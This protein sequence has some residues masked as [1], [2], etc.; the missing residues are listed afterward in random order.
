[1]TAHADLVPA[2]REIP[3]T[4]RRKTP[5]DIRKCGTDETKLCGRNEH[6][7]HFI[8]RFT[9]K[10]RTRKQVSSHIQV[11]KNF[12]RGNDDCTLS[13]TNIAWTA[14]DH[15]GMALVTR[16]SPSQHDPAD[17]GAD[18]E[19]HV[20]KVRHSF[21]NKVPPAAIVGSKVPYQEHS[22]RRIKFEMY[23]LDRE[24]LRR[25]HVYS[26]LQSEIG[27]AS[28][29]LEDA[30]DW[31]TKYPRLAPYYDRG[32]LDVEIILFET[33]FSL[34]EEHPPLKSK[35]RIDF[36]IDIARG[37]EF[38]NWKCHAYFYENDILEESVSTPT[39][40]ELI[41]GTS[42]A[43]IVVGLHSSWWVDHFVALTKQRLQKEQKGDRLAVKPE[44]ERPVCQ[45]RDISVVQEIWATP[46]SSGTSMRMAIFLWNFRQTRNHEAATTTWRKLLAPSR[47]TEP[48]FSSRALTAQQRQPS[49]AVDRTL[50]DQGLLQPAPVYAEYFNPQPSFFVEDLERLDNQIIEPDFRL[51]STSSTPIGDYH[52]FPSSTSTSFPSST[53]SSTLPLKVSQDSA[54]SSQDGNF[55][56]QDGPCILRDIAYDSQ[57]SSYRFRE[58]EYPS[59][60][61]PAYSQDSAHHHHDSGFESQPRD[62]P[63]QDYYQSQDTSYH[64]QHI[65]NMEYHFPSNQFNQHQPTEN[66]YQSSNHMGNNAESTVQDFASMHIQLSICESEDPVPAYDAPCVAPMVNMLGSQ[67]LSGAQEHYRQKS[68][69]CHP[70]RSQIQDHFDLHQWQA[71]DQAVQWANSRLQNRDL[72]EVGDMMG[73]GQVLGEIEEMEREM[74]VEMGLMEAYGHGMNDNL[75]T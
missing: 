18:F 59:Q 17:F 51:K 9:G 13:I 28:R 72:V 8:K 60:N 40:L 4:G 16:A 7:S 24:E 45:I 34:M 42:D 11:L 55:H 3:N 52:S 57:G 31:R 15:L 2:L 41:P 14:T 73:Q 21:L 48:Y 64:P 29:A 35:L 37:V 36:A 47:L 53:S 65:E 26:S 19:P 75:P 54:Y 39:N 70:P 50:Q 10:V 61:S 46:Q 62:S 71:M 58:Y 66:H 25:L 30:K 69:L 20:L 6:I 49:V 1:M 74:N 23:I 27:S 43:R 33:Y 38:T 22:I 44:E 68:S 5:C 32:E 63:S 56:S 67:A 12:Q